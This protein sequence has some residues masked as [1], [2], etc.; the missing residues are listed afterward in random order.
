M[1]VEHTDKQPKFNLMQPDGVRG[2]VHS[3]V[4]SDVLL[5]DGHWYEIKPGSFKFYK[6]NQSSGV[7]VPFVQFDIA[8]TEQY[9]PVAGKRVE[10][11]P[12][13]ICGLAYT[14]SEDDA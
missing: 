8:Y 13:S 9:R 11:F 14:P 1:K 4:I 5:N 10:V 3:E 6:T 7:G 12:A 2:Q